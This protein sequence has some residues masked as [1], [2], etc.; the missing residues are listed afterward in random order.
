MEEMKV[1]P[2]CAEEIK[3]A[4]RVCRY[5]GYRFEPE[6]D[7]VNSGAGE[8]ASAPTIAPAEIDGAPTDGMASVSEPRASERPDAEAGEEQLG[9]QLV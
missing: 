2:D 1:C 6:I 9:V 3:Q 5:C 8:A 7:E 4:A